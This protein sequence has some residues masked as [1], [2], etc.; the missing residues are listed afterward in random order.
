MIVR[1]LEEG[2]YELG[3]DGVARLETLDAVLDEA[4]SSGDEDTFAAALEALIG[5]VRSSGHAVGP[6]EIV[7]SDLVLPAP[8]ATLAE[9]RTLLADDADAPSDGSG[10]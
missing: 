1:V 7:P 2:Q 9:V 6:T 5:E 8:G 3:E 10:R 4:L